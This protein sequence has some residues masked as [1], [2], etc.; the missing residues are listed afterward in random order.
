MTEQPTALRLADAL[1]HRHGAESFEGDAAAELRRSHSKIVDLEESVRILLTVVSER[2]RIEVQRDALLEALKE[3]D[4]WL[5]CSC[6]A[7]AE[8]MAQSFPHMQQV[9]SAAI[10]AVEGEKE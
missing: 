7:T 1:I 9:A 8:D 3:I 4:S 10:K 2:D 5:V 6:I